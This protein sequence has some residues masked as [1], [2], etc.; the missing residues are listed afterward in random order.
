MFWSSFRNYVLL[1]NMMN[2]LDK[3]QSFVILPK[4]GKAPMAIH[5][6]A[7]YLGFNV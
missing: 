4:A 5:V 2:L 3:Y 1:E 6:S 7:F